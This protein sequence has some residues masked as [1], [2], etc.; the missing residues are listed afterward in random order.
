MW[1]PE[2]VEKEKGDVARKKGETAYVRLWQVSGWQKIRK[3]LKKEELKKLKQQGPVI[4][5]KL[6]NQTETRWH[7]FSILSRL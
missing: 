7:L 4:Y 1:H 3:E 6:S 2:G 5:L